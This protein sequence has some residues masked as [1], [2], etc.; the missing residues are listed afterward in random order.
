MTPTP[1]DPI[2]I[3]TDDALRQCCE[4]LSRATRIAVDTEFMRSSTFYPK[5]AL[6][7][8]YAGEVDE[9]RCYLV[10]PVAIG[11][12]HPLRDLLTNH[13]VLKIFHACSEDLEVFSTFLG[14]VPEP[15][16][17]TQIAAALLGYGSALSYAAL[18]ERLLGVSL[19]K[20]ETRS[21]WLQR[22]LQPRQLHYA[23]QDVL[24]LLPV[25][26]AML[27][28]L[29]KNLRLPWWEEECGNLIDAAKTPADPD[30]YYPRIKQ[31]WKLNRQQLAVLRKL[32]HWRELRAREEDRPRNHVLPEMSLWA[33]ARYQ[34]SDLDSMRRIEG[35]EARKLKRYGAELLRLLEEARELPPEDYPPALPPPLP[36]EQRDLMKS[37]K[38]AVNE[39]AE[40]LGLAPEVLVRKA[41]YEYIVRS[42]MDGDYALPARL[43][44]WRSKII[45]ESLL[46]VAAD[47]AAGQNRENGA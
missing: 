17:D 31:A 3:D 47:L 14:C 34:P 10:D 39:R 37:L 15:L 33:L 40:A 1:T 7:Q 26:D 35:M 30:D 4:R 29:E 43:L 25:Y 21:D 8:L 11:N 45:G 41:D 24:Y 6:V 23:M 9:G 2:W 44:G 42:G 38:Q 28:E 22:P 36:L 13:Q 19:E 16:A 46:Q 27:A 12:L 18:V 5:A 32:S 20:G